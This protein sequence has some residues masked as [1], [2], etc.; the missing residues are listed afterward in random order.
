MVLDHQVIY[1]WEVEL[2]AQRTRHE[3]A[4][5]TGDKK[6]MRDASVKITELENKLRS[7]GG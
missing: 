3:E 6:A 2:Q 7:V 5:R 4:A 1:G